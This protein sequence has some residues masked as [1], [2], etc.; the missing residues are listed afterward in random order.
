M[1]LELTETYSL[2]KIK[3][4]LSSPA[5]DRDTARNVINLYRRVKDSP[6]NEILVTYEKKKGHGRY[7]PTSGHHQACYQWKH[8]RATL[9]EGE[10]DIDAVNCSPTIFTALCRQLGIDVKYLPKYLDNRQ[11][12]IDDLDLTQTEID[13][14]NAH[15][16]GCYARYDIGKSVF[17][18]FL[19]GANRNTYWKDTKK[20][21]H[22]GKD[23]IITKSISH[24][25][26]KEMEKA[27]QIILNNV[28]Y[29]HYS[30][31]YK[32][33]AIH[34]VLTDIEA[35]LVRELM[36]KFKTS[37]ISVT[38]YMFDGF[39]VPS[40]D[41]NK[42][43]HI[44]KGYDN[45]YDVKFIRKPFPDTLDKLT[46]VHRSQ[47][48]IEVDL[49]KLESVYAYT[50]EGIAKL[51]CARTDVKLVNG[52]LVK[53]SA[54]VKRY[55]EIEPRGLINDMDITMVN[56]DGNEDPNYLKNAKGMRNVREALNQIWKFHH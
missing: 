27:K 43:D 3:E 45:D 29:K 15:T 16:K 34:Y 24:E 12:F 52:M 36:R 39:Q 22:L 9:S 30:E 49:K 8:L 41:H 25:L 1:S 42:I 21:M 14:H 37:G 18:A 35:Y 32:R 40:T 48:Q 44:L 54:K 28:Q 33:G 51:C 26:I 17:N 5:L 19:N 55:I 7:Y 50:D 6:N 11:Q 13:N 10:T 47:E 53:Y 2:A 46:I 23:V 38:K 20:G 4:A 56:E 31:K